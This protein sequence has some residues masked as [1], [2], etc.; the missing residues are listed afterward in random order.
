VPEALRETVVEET[1]AL[2]AP[3]LRDDEGNWTADYIRLRFIARA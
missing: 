3:V 2:L 1:A